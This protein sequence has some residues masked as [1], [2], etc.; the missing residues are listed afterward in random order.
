MV[1]GLSLLGPWH[2]QHVQKHRAENCE[3]RIMGV[4]HDASLQHTNGIP[5]L[6]PQTSPVMLV[7]VSG[8]PRLMAGIHDAAFVAENFHITYQARCAA[9]GCSYS[10]Q[11]LGGVTNPPNGQWLF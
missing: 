5:A 7:A 1:T 4:A 2:C 3:P 10:V 8:R 9:T 11:Q 6:V